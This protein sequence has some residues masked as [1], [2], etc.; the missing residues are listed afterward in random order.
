MPVTVKV[1]PAT[2]TAKVTDAFDAI[3]PQ[4]S[5][6]ILADCN[7]YCKEDST[8]L[9][10]SSISHSQMKEG[11][12]IWETP[13]ARRQYWSIETAYKDVNPKATWKW[14]EAAKA[15]EKE[16]WRLQAEALMRSKL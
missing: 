1:N 4:L 9:I 8:A 14:C 12:L 15:K 11:K 16:K 5:E 10:G 6:L 13:Y 7:E 3:L 2:V